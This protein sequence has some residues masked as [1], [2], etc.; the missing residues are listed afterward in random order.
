MR[1]TWYL[2]DSGRLVESPAPAGWQAASLDPMSEIWLDIENPEPEQLR[3]LLA[4]LALHPLVLA[5]CLMA[6]NIPG[7]LSSDSAVLLEFP[8][9]LAAEDDDP[10]YL[11]LALRSG[12]LLTLRSASMPALDDLVRELTGDEAAVIEDLAQLM[13]LMLDHLADLPAAL[14]RFTPPAGADVVEQK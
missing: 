14:F 12:V 6:K 13:Y 7:T 4:P 11:T 2:L 5:R 9:V 8:A 10:T 3:T 1:V